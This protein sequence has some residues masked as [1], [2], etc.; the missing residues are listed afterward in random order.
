KSPHKSRF[1]RKQNTL[2]KTKGEPPLRYAR[3]GASQSGSLPFQIKSAKL[4]SKGATGT[5]LFDN[6]KHRLDRSDTTVKL[7]S[8]LTISIGGM[9]TD[10]DLN[11][12]QTT[13]VTTS[14]KNPVGK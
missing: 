1:E 3:P 2:Y 10:V 7:E 11:Q 8:K 14:D 4:D 9:T 13:T 6:E 12:E 5:I